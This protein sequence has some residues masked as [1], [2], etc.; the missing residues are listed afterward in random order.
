MFKPNIK[1]LNKIKPVCGVGINDFHD[2]VKMNGKHIREYTLWKSMLTRCYKNKFYTDC[3]VEEYLLSFTNFYN[4]I[5]TLVG[6]DNLAYQLDKDFLSGGAKIYSRDTIVFVPKELNLF[7]TNR[8]KHRGKYLQGVSYKNGKFVAQISIDSTYTFLGNFDDE[9]TAHNEYVRYKINHAK[10][11]A[12][13][14][15]NYIDIRVYQK[16]LNFNI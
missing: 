10:V 15:K 16:L 6:Y 1:Q 3:T 11:L 4:H 12:E 8:S 7:L 9:I 13:R 14:W 2:C 5:H